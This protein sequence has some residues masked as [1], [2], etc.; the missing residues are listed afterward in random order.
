MA[1]VAAGRRPKAAFG[2]SRQVAARHVEEGPSWAG[3]KSQVLGPGSVSSRGSGGIGAVEASC[4]GS[5][6]ANLVALGVRMLGNTCKKLRNMRLDVV[7]AQHLRK[8]GVL[9]S[10]HSASFPIPPPTA[11]DLPPPPSRP[12]IA[13]S[14]TPSFPVY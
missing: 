1:R 8:V 13:P 3:G 2:P 12:S 10:S 9:S 11:G 14:S 4:R 5:E 6:D 7:I